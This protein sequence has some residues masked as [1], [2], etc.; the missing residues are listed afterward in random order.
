M[1][2]VQVPVVKGKDSVDI[3]TDAI[4]P[5]VWSAVIEAGLKVFVNGGASKITKAAYNGDEGKLKDAAMA[6]AQERVASMLDGTIKI[7]GKKAAKKG[8]DREVNTEAMRLAKAH[9]KDLMREQGLKISHYSAKEITEAAKN[10]LESMPELYEEAKANIAKRKEAV[11]VEAKGIDLS[12]LMKADPKL[13]A[14]AAEAAAKKKKG[15]LSAK[16]AGM[17]AKRKPKAAQA[18]A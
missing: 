12:K 11:A 5:E 17:T 14:K 7:P 16:Q 8:G 10:V 18:Q 6:K 1:A 4:P 13:V 15:S 2:I 3:D 9:V